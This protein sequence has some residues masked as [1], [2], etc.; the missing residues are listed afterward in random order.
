MKADRPN[1]IVI[2]TDQQRLDSLSCM[3]SSFV[4]T[5]NLD[6]LA[7]DGVLFR[8]A[9][10]T[11]PVCTP[12][13]AS[14]FSGFQVSRHGAWNVGTKIPADIPLLTH[15]LA[16]LGY[17]THGIGKM[18][19]QP[20]GTVESEESLE[21]WNAGEA[22]T[23]GPYYGFETM[24][25][26]C[27][28]TT[29]G[30]TGTYGEW[31]LEQV[32]GNRAALD[33]FRQSRRLVEPEFGGAAYET[34]LP[35]RLQNSV[36]TA[37]RACAFLRDHHREAGGSAGRRPF[38]L[39]IGFEDPH[40]PHAVPSD[41]ANRVDPASVPLPAYTPGELNDKPPHFAANRD[42]TLNAGDLRGEYP[43][44]GVSRGNDTVTDEA[45]RLGRAHYYTLVQLID[46]QVGRIVDCIDELG[47]RE[48]TIIVFTTDHGELLGDHGMWCKGPFH[49]EQLVNVPL[50][51]RGPAGF[52]RPRA[53]DALVSHVDLVPTIMAA[54]GA[55]L[56]V[57]GDGSV[58]G[59]DLGPLLRGETSAARDHVLIECVDDP[60]KLRLKTI[61]TAS[62][63]CTWYASHA[64][65]ELYDLAH[66]PGEMTNLWS[67]RIDERARFLALML[68]NA[69]RVERR[70][71]RWCYA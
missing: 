28:H 50:I 17:R 36:W 23:R 27:G 51:V 60:Q 65:G 10:C 45:A 5:P 53:T 69:E 43:V 21:R 19:F 37:E 63:K 39:A 40:H 70:A 4:R 8:R 47:L 33:G 29:Y 38:F 55:P 71:H 25:L 32:A 18:H 31:V 16:A 49:Y 42:G 54:A 30:M 35:W 62:A 3:G 2:T 46:E 24:E 13:R 12:S 57:S 52:A 22:L 66:D 9:Y 59:V 44:A 67:E 41:Y 58:D 20:F 6:R 48:R 11:N 7:H 14:I 15:R 34:S 56:P 64:F 61:V 68:E 1:V 26:A